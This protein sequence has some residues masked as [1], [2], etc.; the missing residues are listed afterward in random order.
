MINKFNPYLRTL[1]ISVPSF[2]LIICMYGCKKDSSEATSPSINQSNTN[3]TPTALNSKLTAVP[4][5]SYDLTAS[6][7]QGYVKNGTVD[8]TTYI[9]AA[10]TKNSNVT[11][12]NFPILIDDAGLSIPSNRTVNFLAGSQ[13]LLKPTAKANYN[14]LQIS[15]ASNVVLNNPVIIGDAAKHLGTSGEWGMGIGVYSSSNIQINGATVSYCWGDGI[16]LST[17]QGTT[18]NTNITISNAYLTYNRR[19]QMS[20][21]SVNGLDLESPY[22]SYSTQISPMCGFDFEPN[23]STD[24]LQNI[25]VNN[26]ITEGNAGFGIQIAYSKLYGGAN[27]T[28]SITVNNQNDKRSAVAFKAAADTT[29]RAGKETISGQLV[30]NSPEWRLN[31]TSPLVGSISER[32]IKL[33]ITKPTVED[34]TGT[35]LTQAAVLT[36]LTYKTHMLYGS[37]YV[38]TF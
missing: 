28:T 29:K 3:A 14:I 24:E 19:N 18:T 34:T 35:F 38:I 11:F 26:P 25:V 31:T 9:Q 2:L 13:L 17:S 37:N 6:L 5:G 36:D 27:K 8:Y 30:I 7:P 15:H 23:S 20:V 21:T 1:K 4:A 10:I 16:Y 22:A 33:T 12:P 32:N